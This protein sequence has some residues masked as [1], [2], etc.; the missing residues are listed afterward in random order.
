MN[1]IL[2]L[3]LLTVTI[4]SCRSV[5]TRNLAGRIVL[6]EVKASNDTV[7]F[8]I[9]E[10]KLIDVESLKACGYWGENTPSFNIYISVTNKLDKNIYLIPLHYS[11]VFIGVF[12]KNDT[13]NFANYWDEY[14]GL[15]TPESSVDVVVGSIAMYSGFFDPTQ[16]DNTEP[17]LHLIKGMKFYYAPLP[18]EVNIGQDTVII[19]RPHRLRTDA[20]TKITS[21]SRVR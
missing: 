14:P 19:D 7:D 3:I 11:D 1:K 16:L 15:L 20:N 8:Y 4:I 21:W 13:V 12:Q 10:I 2:F 6:D 9:K 18:R 5:I 17:L